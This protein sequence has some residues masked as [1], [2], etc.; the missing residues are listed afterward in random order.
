MNN[1]I[2]VR[3]QLRGTTFTGIYEVV[4]GQV[5][6]VSPDFGER[7]APLNGEHPR[8]IAAWLLWSMANEAVRAGKQFMRDDETS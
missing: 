3:V 2:N 5:A 7:T 8:D 4:D 1:D 6:L